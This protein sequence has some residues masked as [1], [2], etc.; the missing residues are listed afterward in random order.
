[1]K[2]YVAHSREFNFKKEL[3]KPL[4]DSKLGNKTNFVFSHKTKAFSPSRKKIKSVDYVI[5]EVSYPS[6]GLGIELGWANCIKFP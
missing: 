2:I 1:M 5:A 4:R 6:T 3:Y